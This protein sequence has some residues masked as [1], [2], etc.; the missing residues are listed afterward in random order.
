MKVRMFETVN[1]DTEV[2]VSA[3]DVLNEFAARF[4]DAAND[5]SCPVKFAYIP[6]VDFATKLL[7]QIPDL[8]IA[9]CTNQQRATVSDRLRSESERWMY[10]AVED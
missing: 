6:L 4:E 3:V 5:G 1:V 10:A 2:D 9:K 7:A 8:A